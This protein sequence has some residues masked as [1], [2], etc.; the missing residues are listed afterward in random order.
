MP[1]LAV[2]VADTTPYGAPGVYS[3]WFGSPLRP[4]MLTASAVPQSAPMSATSSSSEK[5]YPDRPS[6]T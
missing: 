2:A 1:E 4:P 6:F 3:M 5:P